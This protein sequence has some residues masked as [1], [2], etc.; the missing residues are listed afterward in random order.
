MNKQDAIAIVDKLLVNA[1]GKL[2]SRYVL[3]LER[4]KESLERESAE[5]SLKEQREWLDAIER[6]KEK[7]K[8]RGS[9]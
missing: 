6:A 4:A 1:Q 2:C 5:Q 9:N 7:Y 8:K 3:G